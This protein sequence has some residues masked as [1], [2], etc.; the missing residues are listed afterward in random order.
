MATGAAG[1]V[2]GELA[3]ATAALLDVFVGVTGVRLT[4]GVGVR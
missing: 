3:A 1:A 4:S 2:S